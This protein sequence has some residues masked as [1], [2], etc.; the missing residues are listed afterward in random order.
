M[1]VMKK[2]QI[3]REQQAKEYTLRGSVGKA[4]KEW[5]AREISGSVEFTGTDKLRTSGD[6]QI[7]TSSPVCTSINNWLCNLNHIQL[8]AGLS[9]C[10]MTWDCL[11]VFLNT[12]IEPLEYRYDSASEYSW[13]WHLKCCSNYTIMKFVHTCVCVKCVRKQPEV[14][15]Q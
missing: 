2:K 11:R 1:Y 15:C 7:S 9:A 12:H 5:Q 3:I 6:C 4:P 14:L 13:C 8:A 10:L